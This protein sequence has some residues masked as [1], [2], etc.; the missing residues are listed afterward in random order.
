MALLLFVACNATGPAGFKGSYSF[1]TG[2]YITVSAGDEQMVRHLI[3]E[4]GQMHVLQDRDMM[5][6]TMNITAGDPVVFEANV[7]D[8]RLVLKP[9]LRSV[10]VSPVLGDTELRYNLTVGGEGKKMDN[11]IVFKLEYTGVFPYEGKTY[12]VTKSDVSCIA[13]SNE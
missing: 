10:P 11:M 9:V 3:P 4:S 13:T 7:A 8:G 2:G 12:T 5:L 6:V 1:K